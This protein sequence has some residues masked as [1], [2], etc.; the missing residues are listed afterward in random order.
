MSE[1]PSVNGSNPRRGVRFREE[2]AGQLTTGETDPIAGYRGRGTGAITMYAAIE[3]ADVPAFIADPGHNAE[4]TAEIDIPRLGGRFTSGVGHFGLFVPTEDARVTNMV[5]ELP[6]VIDGED[7]LLRGVKP[8]R[9]AAPW[10]LWPAT[11]TLLTTLHQGDSAEGKVVAAGAL[12]LGMKELVAMVRTMEGTADWAVERW[13]RVAQ[14]LGFFTG[15]L[16]STYLL[17]RRA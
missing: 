6:V 15:G 2:M 8:I 13:W 7:H 9:V 11:T 4:L 1:G 10:R 5:Y 12:R 14:F 3:I 16:V 17:R